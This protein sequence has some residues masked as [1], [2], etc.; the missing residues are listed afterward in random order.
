VLASCQKEISYNRDA[1]T[2][3][4]G[5]TPPT[6]APT[7]FQ[8]AYGGIKGDG[9]NSIV[10]TKDGGFV[11]AGGTTS[12][13]TGPGSAVGSIY[14]IRTNSFGDTIWTRTIRNAKDEDMS[15]SSIQ[16]TNDGG[17]IICGSTGVF[18]PSLWLTDMVLMKT[19]SSGR[20]L[21]TK[22][23]KS[24]LNNIT[25]TNL[26]NEVRQTSDEGY[27]VVGTTQSFGL[28]D[29]YLIKTD[30]SGNL[31]WSKSFGNSNTVYPLSVQVRND[32]YT[33]EGYLDNSNVA[34]NWDVFMIKMDLNGNNIWAKIYDR[35]AKFEDMTSGG[36]TSDGGYFMAGEICAD[37]CNVYLM[38]ADNNGNVLWCKTYGGGKDDWA[39][40]AA[41]TSDGGFV[42]AGGTRSFG[43]GEE[44]VYLIRTDNSGNLIWSKTFGGL[45]SDNA[46]FLTPAKDGGFIV[47]AST[48]SFGAGGND[49]YIIK[50]DSKGSSGGCNE[51]NPATNV[52]VA[53]ANVSS[54]TPTTYSGSLVADISYTINGGGI[55][56]KICPK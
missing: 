42:I 24:T 23:Y 9:I 17:Y 13:G 5:S 48:T 8:K 28:D 25:F 39:W 22:S 11:M 16:S 50:T 12:Y 44:D 43:A 54:F 55:V 20:P 38:R 47:A 18:D 21:W 52:S 45:K 6:P 32:G 10:Q 31:Q 35:P 19:D 36:Q 2:T 49:P 29:G 30:A 14:L 56:T 26:A 34:G 27:V 41:Q 1:N 3:S 4:T 53:S 33:V 15:A 37:S 7:I 51:S 46:W 40:S